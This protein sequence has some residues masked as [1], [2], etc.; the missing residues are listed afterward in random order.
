MCENAETPLKN[1]HDT[2]KEMCKVMRERGIE[3]VEIG[4]LEVFVKDYSCIHCRYDCEPPYNNDGKGCDG[5]VQEEEV[6][7]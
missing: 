6:R 2:L 1:Y 5:F 3:R 7:L 4:G